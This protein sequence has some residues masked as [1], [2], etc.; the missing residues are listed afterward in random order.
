MLSVTQISANQAESYY[1]KD[2]GYYTKEP[3]YWDG[4]GSQLLG[5][6]GA[7][8]KKD[9]RNLLNG[10]DPEGNQLVTTHNGREHRA[11]FDLTFSAPKSLSILSEIAGDIRLR[12]AHRTAVTEALRYLESN[13]SGIRETVDGVTRP[14]ATDNLIIAR[15]EHNTSRGPNMDCQVHTHCVVLNASQ[16]NDKFRALDAHALYS[17]KLLIG[18][19]YRNAL[20]NELIQKHYSVQAGKHG[21]IEVE[22][23]PKQIITEFSTRRIEI[24]K[25]LN[26]RESGGALAEKITLSSRPAKAY[27]N[28][29]DLHREWIRRTSE[30]GYSPERLQQEALIEKGVRRE[31]VDAVIHL[32]EAIK[33]L[34]TQTHVWSKEQMLL[35]TLRNGVANGLTVD[36]A[37]KQIQKQ[38]ENRGLIQ[39]EGN[40][41]TS[42]EAIRLEQTIVDL[43]SNRQGSILPRDSR[44]IDSVIKE[45]GSHLNPGQENAV[46]FMTGSRDGVIGIE[47]YAGVGKTTMVSVAN[48]CWEKEGFTVRGLA[49]TGKAAET[50]ET[51]AG[52]KSQTIHSF[53]GE[54]EQGT[55]MQ[56]LKPQVWIVDEA[57]MVGSKQMGHLLEEAKRENAK[58]ILLGDR[59]QLQPIDAGKPYQ[60]L[61]ERGV[62]STVRVEEILRQK[63]ELKLVVHAV[64]KE[65]DTDK[66][67]SIL[68][69]KL[70]AIKE[71][72]RREERLK[73]MAQNYFAL[74]PKEMKNTLLIT[75]V[76]ADRHLINQYTREG[77][78]E[79]GMINKE[80]E[81]GYIATIPKRIPEEEKKFGESYSKGDLIRFTSTSKRLE[82]VRSEKG[83]VTEIRGN[84]LQVQMEN[85][86]REVAVNLEK[87]RQIEAYSPEKRDF[88]IGD[89][90]MFLR[91]DKTLN[92]VNGSVGTVTET[93]NHIL[94]IDTRNGT[95]EVDL[96][97]YGH[98][99]HA[100]STTITKSQGMTVKNVILNIDTSQVKSL[101][102]NAFYIG[103]SRATHGI[104]VLV[105]NKE[106]LPDTVRQWQQKESTLDYEKGSRLDI[107]IGKSPERSVSKEPEMTI[108]RGMER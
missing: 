65:L 94:K 6:E 14:V 95:K 30:L 77:L 78:K 79:K 75:A 17:T 16:S 5:L 28:R 59:L 21:V 106:K 80:S 43:V 96:K 1:A 61:I 13:Y 42:R 45:Y 7:V 69:N 24:L 84:V 101:S 18:Q 49:F 104:Q 97:S 90:V 23:V 103:V 72:P 85:G 83:I 4:K 2:Q 56:A 26:G 39:L 50:L 54:K 86:N 41:Y 20:A 36:A 55:G 9:F 51:E 58:I 3:G 81:K 47:G 88:G 27:T 100:Y 15:F 91:N 67:L 76:N 105:D 32:K 98:L 66:A 12:E 29:E 10:K 99:D 52:I 35:S 53:L 37:E 73:A 108:H 68:E 93:G 46:R 57:S 60:N 89:K 40:K 44:Q 19:V 70:N 102:A 38:I 11:G 87:F 8:D 34:E 33:G 82:V 74:S 22:H 92:V 48:Q 63:T 31:P 107:D 25:E 62:L 64:A 71:I